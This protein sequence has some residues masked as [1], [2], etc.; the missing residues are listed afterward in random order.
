M[1]REAWY[2]LTTKEKSKMAINMD[3]MRQKLAALRGDTRGSETSVWFKPD[4]GE[5]SIRI[6]PAPDGDP[7]REMFFH[8][9]VGN[10]KG[11]VLC[12]KKN[13]G[14]RCPIC[15]FASQLWRDGSDNNDDETKNLAKSLFVRTRYFS[16]IVVRGQ[17]SEGV[18]VYG[19]GK[20][21]YEM[22]LG[23][24]LDPDYGDITDENHG[25]DIKL[26]Y[27]KPTRPG[28]YPQTTLKMNR[29]TSPLADSRGEIETVLATMPDFDT[30]FKRHTPEEVEAILDEQMATDTTAENSSKEVS[31]Y[32]NNSVDAAYNELLAG[33]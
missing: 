9:N 23:Y 13:F 31:R 16:P 8:Y 32:G 5:T 21:A 11:G 26:T 15:D 20:K 2:T 14:E 10:H 18:K 7:L 29:N 22:L 1:L 30:L 24:I 25:T 17:E 19:Y 3:L 27:T 28:A 6:V 12:P 33:K 4:E